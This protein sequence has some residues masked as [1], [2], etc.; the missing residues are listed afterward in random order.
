MSPKFFP[1]FGTRKSA[2]YTLQKLQDMVATPTNPAYQ[3]WAARPGGAGAADQ[4]I[5]DFYDR[6]HSPNHTAGGIA[7]AVNNTLRRDNGKYGVN[8]QTLNRFAGRATAN[9]YSRG[10]SNKGNHARG[11]GY[12]PGQRKSEYERAADWVI[13]SSSTLNGQ[14]TGGKAWKDLV[15]AMQVVVETDG[16]VSIDT[17]EFLH[18]SAGHI[19]QSSRISS[20]ANLFYGTTALGEHLLPQVFNI[21]RPM[22]TQQFLNANAKAAT[23]L[24]VFLMIGTI[25]A[26][27]FGDGNGRSARA[28]YACVQIK[29]GNRF[30]PAAYRW[31]L[32]QTHETNINT[33]V[34]A[35]VPDFVRPPNQAQS[36]RHEGRIRGHTMETVDIAAERAREEAE[37]ELF[38]D[39]IVNF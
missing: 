2:G 15:H 39:L 13:K 26:H 20:E 35:G 3:A 24:A 33:V 31:V 25:L 17:L 14:G 29:Y 36:R 10:L 5:R 30:V 34:N 4:M 8:I 11:E 1:K 38:G 6:H 19:A 12:I 23:D 27:P 7:D 22:M 28:L 37:R 21:A 32:N 16:M 9:F 18:A